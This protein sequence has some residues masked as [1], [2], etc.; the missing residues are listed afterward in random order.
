MVDKFK[1]SDLIKRTHLYQWFQ[2]FW[3]FRIQNWWNHMTIKF[4]EIFFWKIGFLTYVHIRHWCCFC[5]QMLCCFFRCSS[6]YLF[7]EDT[8]RCQRESRVNCCKFTF[9]S[10]QFAK[11]NVLVVLEQFLEPFFNTPLS[12][13]AAQTMYP[14][15]WRLQSV[16]FLPEKISLWCEKNTP[17]NTLPTAEISNGKKVRTW[18]VSKI[19][20]TKIALQK[21]SSLF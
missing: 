1:T 15:G 3:N 13:R 12:Y 7:D 9:N 18:V 16:I 14:Q 21:F 6:R 19:Q 17:H 10:S 11:D 5:Q 20:Q 8:L 4:A 2:S